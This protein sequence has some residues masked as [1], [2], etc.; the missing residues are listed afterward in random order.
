MLALRNVVCSDRWDE[1]WPPNCADP[2]P[3]GAAAARDTA[4]AAA[5]CDTHP[6]G[7]ASA[8][9]SGASHH[10]RHN[11]RAAMCTDTPESRSG[12][13]WRALAAAGQS[14]LATYA[15]R[16]RPFQANE[17]ETLNHTQP[18]GQCPLH[19][20]QPPARGRSH[21]PADCRLPQD[22]CVRTAGHL[23]EVICSRGGVFPIGGQPNSLLLPDHDQ[24]AIDGGGKR[25][26]KLYSWTSTSK[27]FSTRV[28]RPLCGPITLVIW[29]REIPKA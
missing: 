12:S 11:N 6:D 16:P 10:A 4:P 14:S 25:P 23:A 3:A 27:N 15:G 24:R 28:M 17:R 19:R 26:S 18:R 8:A 13:S 2:A 22:A 1:A 29:Y 9:A 7:T 5:H 21:R 20:T